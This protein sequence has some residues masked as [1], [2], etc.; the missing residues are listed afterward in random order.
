MPRLRKTDSVD[1][2]A[3]SHKKDSESPRIRQDWDRVVC[4][5]SVFHPYGSGQNR[6]EGNSVKAISWDSKRSR[7]E[8]LSP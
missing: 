5:H 1:S 7:E 4:S 3:F 8:T 6:G 2:E